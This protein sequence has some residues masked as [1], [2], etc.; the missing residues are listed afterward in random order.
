MNIKHDKG[1]SMAMWKSETNSLTPSRDSADVRSD[2]N[3]SWNRGSLESQLLIKWEY[4]D[5]REN[6][7]RSIFSIDKN[8]FKR[9]AIHLRAPRGARNDDKRGDD[10]VEHAEIGPSLH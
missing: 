8:T 10:D 6:K 7:N 9:D 1:V 4:N 2:T 3:V 5:A